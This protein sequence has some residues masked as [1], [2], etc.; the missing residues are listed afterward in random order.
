MTPQEPTYVRGTQPMTREVEGEVVMFHPERGEYFALG[1]VGSRIWVLLEQPGT[2]TELC[3]RLRREFDIDD[4]TCRL[5]VQA[6]LDELAAAG[7]VKT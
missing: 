3:D 1:E 7:L 6:F 4:D 5:Q 2:V